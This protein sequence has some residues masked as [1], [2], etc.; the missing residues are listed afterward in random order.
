M[1]LYCKFD[2]VVVLIRGG[3]NRL[4]CINKQHDSLLN[5]EKV[6][7]FDGDITKTM[8]GLSRSDYDDIAA[9]V[10]YCVHCAARVD[11]AA[12]YND[13]RATNVLGTREVVAFAKHIV[14]KKFIYISTLSVEGSPLSYEKGYAATKYV[15]E[16]IVEQN[17]PAMNVSIL[18]LPFVLFNSET[19]FY[20]PSDW[21]MR[22]L[23]SC[24]DLKVFPLCTSQ[25]ICCRVNEMDL[26]N[27][28]YF[29]LSLDLLFLQLQSS[30][31]PAFKV[32]SVFT[33]CGMLETMESAASPVVPLLREA[34]L[35]T[36]QYP[37]PQ[38]EIS[39]DELKLLLGR[40]NREG[41]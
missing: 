34:L 4:D 35:D 8:F 19:G 39:D 24:L 13:L 23:K 36:R 21:L 22:L 16:R 12:S 18:R 27:L 29:C 41:K 1:D 25:L 10:S 14:E 11:F 28:R 32:V 30:F 17:L 6:R 3:E 38:I 9:H 26:E 7:V 40:I 15:G 20:N 33:L 2:E 37:Y 5:L 31:F